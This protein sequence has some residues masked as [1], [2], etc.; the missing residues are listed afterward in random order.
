MWTIL[1]GLP[2]IFLLEGCAS[3]VP[4][5]G[6]EWVYP[7]PPEKPRIRYVRSL[8]GRQDLKK[9]F[10]EKITDALAGQS[11][12]DRIIK[13]YGVGV[14]QRGRVFV[15]GTGNGFVLV[16]DENAEKSKDRF[17]LL[18]SEHPG[19]LQSPVDIVFDKEGNIYVSDTVLRNIFVY[20]PD[21]KFR[22]A[23]GQRDS[24]LRPSGMAYDLKNNRLVVIDTWDHSVKF[25]SPDGDLL[26]SF[27]SRGLADTCFN[28]PTNVTVDK[29]GNI[30]VV[31]T[32]NFRVKIFS[33]NMKLVRAFGQASR[34]PGS[35]TRP[36]GIALDPEG[37]I[38]VVDTDP[39]KVQIFD[40][41]GRLLLYF[42]SLGTGPGEFW[43]PAGI[44]IDSAG[45]IYVADQYNH[46][47]EIFQYVSQQD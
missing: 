29:E 25:F 46:R 19:K 5:I 23:I 32:M 18:G 17:W 22:M 30:Y 21:G 26:S 8:Y 20:D 38:Y 12:E 27:G 35:F 43:H 36:K 47:V 16:F 9:S 4:S 1:L 3:T 14:D 31:D 44:E 40:K 24:L 6:E 33:E 34:V 11:Q 39:Q 42:G 45:R 2:L 7:L 28:F 37:H 41:E 15:A 10:F 13:P